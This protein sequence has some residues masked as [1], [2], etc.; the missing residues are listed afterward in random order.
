MAL[1]APL[2]TPPAANTTLVIG[3]HFAPNVKAINI[4]KCLAE[5]CTPQVAACTKDATCNDGIK[6][7]EACPAPVTAKCA[8][9]CISKYMDQTMLE[10]GLCASTNGCL[11]SAFFKQQE[12]SALVDKKDCGSVGACAWCTAEGTP[13][14]CRSKVEAKRLSPSVFKCE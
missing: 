4:T 10:I 2:S 7:V 13:D 12:C 8:E 11:P 9:A 3:D 14:G 5:H 1:A 6:C